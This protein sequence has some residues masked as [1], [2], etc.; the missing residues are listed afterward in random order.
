MSGPPAIEESMWSCIL[1]LQQSAFAPYILITTNGL[2]GL[3]HLTRLDLGANQ[4]DSIDVGSFRQLADLNE[5]RLRAVA[6][7]S[8]RASTGL[9][10]CVLMT[11]KSEILSRALLIQPPASLYG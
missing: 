1:D 4:I 7:A 5:L 2:S 8:F 10:N 6:Q 11:T 9:L 3:G